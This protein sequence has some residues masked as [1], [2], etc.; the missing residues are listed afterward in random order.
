M[1]DEAAGHNYRHGRG[2]DEAHRRDQALFSQLLERHTALRRVTEPL[3][4][5][6]RVQTL[7]DDPQLAEVLW[8]HVEGMDAR[9]AGGRAI[10]SWDPL[11][12]ALFEFRAQI[13]MDYRQ[14]P[15][16]VEAVL[17]AEDPKL[18]E[19]IHAHDE[20][21]HA[22]VEKGF[23]AS[24]HPSPVPDWV[25]AHYGLPTAAPEPDSV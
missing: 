25:L 5:G 14:V 11:F 24:K 8:Q 2:T 16:G 23:E 13:R 4:N 3:P 19:L 22:F 17:T 12:S 1:G 6:I 9:F 21:L 15:G 10:R 20:T 18:V 7:S